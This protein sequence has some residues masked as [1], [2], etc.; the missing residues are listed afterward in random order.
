MKLK[1]S[2]L[3]L[4]GL[5]CAVSI[6]AVSARPSVEAQPNFLEAT[7]PKQFGDWREVQEVAQVIDPGTRELLKETYLETLTRTYING[8]G[9]RVMLSIARSA[10]QLGIRQAHRPETCYPAQGFKLIG[11]LDAGALATPYG[12]IEVNRLTTAKGA[13]SESVTYWLTM[14]DQVVQSKWEKR[15][16]Q[17]RAV[18]TGQSPDGL[19]FRVSSIDRD[20]HGAFSTQ[21]QFVGDMMKSV[22]PDA[23]RRLSGLR[24]AI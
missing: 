9:Y 16:V 8:S 19:L 5:M 2:A 1:S 11:D 18:V 17:L 21:Q 15:V 20:A 24:A 22:T 6:A 23:R 12:Q 4:A 3:V 14:A 13:R 10:D 7:V